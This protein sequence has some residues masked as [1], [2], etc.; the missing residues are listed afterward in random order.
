M[1]QFTADASH[2]LRTPIS[3]IR[4]TSELA[5]RR[6]RAP[7][8]YRK[9]LES[10]NQESQWM[11]Q[12]AED[13]LLLARADAGALKLQSERLDVDPLVQGIAR[14]TEPMAEVRGIQLRTHLGAGEVLIQAD[15]HALRRILAILLE[16]AIQHTPVEGT[17]EVETS[18]TEGRVVIAV[19]DTGDGIPGAD[20][21]YIFERFYRGDPART[22]RTGAG[23][24]LAIARSLAHALGV[25]IE[26]ESDAGKGAEFLLRFAVADQGHLV[27]KN[28]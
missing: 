17:I 27:A 18:S 23:L 7:D 21:P 28:S 25:E 15:A 22:R 16:N 14:E 1:R 6:D 13:L 24:G 8:E 11:T 2:E 20:L 10:I 4:T 9:A 26:V 3:I 12:L 19:R 5:L